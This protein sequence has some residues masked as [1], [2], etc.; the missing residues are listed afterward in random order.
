MEP[1]LIA[2]KLTT[3]ILAYPPRPTELMLRV[4]RYSPWSLVTVVGRVKP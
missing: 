3:T 2:I 4:A 1:D